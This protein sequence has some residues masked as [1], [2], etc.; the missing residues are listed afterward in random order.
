[1]RIIFLRPSMSPPG[2]GS[3]VAAWML[4]AL[5]AEHEVTVLS[6]WP[7]D[8]ELMNRFWGTSLR[9]GDFRAIQPSPRLRRAVDRLPFQL[10]ML[11]TA[12]LVREARR[13]RAGWDLPVAAN[14]EMDFGTAGVQY[15]NYP[16]NTFPRLEWRRYPWYRLQPMRRAYWALCQRVSPFTLEGSRRNVTLSVSNWAGRLMYERYGYVTRTVYPPITSRFPD[17]PWEARAPGFVCIGRIVRE[18]DLD[19]VIDIV[20]GVRRRVPEVTL[21]IVGTPDD[22]AYHEH[23]ARRTREAGF[24]LHENLSRAALVDLVSRQRYGIHG[25]REEHFGM[26]PAE[27]VRGGCLVWV[28]D[29]GGQVEIVDEPRLTYGS[30]DDAVA[31]ILAVIGDPHAVVTL[32]KHLAARAE[33]F[34]AE[35]FM[36][37]VRAAVT[38]AARAA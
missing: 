7:V 3:G 21:H 10:N 28:P 33:I 15:V 31:K 12:L 30:V 2:G 17:V 6:W 36:R 5:V 9:A 32:R 27:M 35:R 29:G 13:R 19:G 20:S 25:M 8:V 18:K 26:A 24:T 34:S 37:E 1:M 4:Q 14:D 16:W 38:D 11:R 23:V 22:R